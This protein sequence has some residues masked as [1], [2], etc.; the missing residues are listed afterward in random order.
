MFLKKHLL[1]TAAAVFF[2][3]CHWSV[4]SLPLT[5]FPKHMVL[6]EIQAYESESKT[7]NNS[8][9]EVRLLWRI[10]VIPDRRLG[11][12]C[13]AEILNPASLLPRK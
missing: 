7:G 12:I 3:Y 5:G 11:A 2:I 1:K 8:K 10:P 9:V 13:A 6:Q 4:N